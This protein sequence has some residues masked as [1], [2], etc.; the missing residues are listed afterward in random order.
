MGS[1]STRA[2]HIP[3]PRADLSLSCSDSNVFLLIH[4][5]KRW[6]M[7][8]QLESLLHSGG[9]PGET[10]SRLFLPGTMLGVEG[11]WG[12]NQLGLIME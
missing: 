10:V 5:G 9:D 8:K 2:A 1:S 3:D 12:V 11:I 6:M 4:L 7:I